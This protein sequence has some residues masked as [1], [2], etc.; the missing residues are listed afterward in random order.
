MS[1]AYEQP[2]VRDFAYRATLAFTDAARSL[3]S[4]CV[5][6]APCSRLSAL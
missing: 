1:E 4:I 3:C 6:K 2:M 5:D